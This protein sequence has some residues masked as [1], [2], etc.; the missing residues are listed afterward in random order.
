M[1]RLRRKTEMSRIVL[2]P[3][4]K[5]IVDSNDKC[6]IRDSFGLGPFALSLSLKKEFFLLRNS[7]HLKR[8][9]AEKLLDS[10]SPFPAGLY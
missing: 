1:L 3:S 9:G 5:N 4:Q 8:Y 10:A 7:V 2:Y 6:K